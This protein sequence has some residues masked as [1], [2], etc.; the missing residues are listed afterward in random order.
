MAVLPLQ[1]YLNN[2]KG[3]PP[4]LILG[5][6]ATSNLGVIHSLATYHIP[7]IVL[8]SRQQS[9]FFSRYTLGIQSPN[10]LLSEREYIGF[11]LK[12]GQ[13]IPAKAVLIP[14]GD[15]ETL[16]LAKY[17][18]ELSPYFLSTSAPYDLLNTLINKQ[19]LFKLLEQYHIPHPQTFIIDPGSNLTQASKDVLYPCILKP[20]YPSRFRQDFPI[21]CFRVSS[22]DQF[23]TQVGKATDKGHA[24][25]AQE[26]IPGNAEAMH[27]F[28]AYFD[29]SGG[30]HGPFM[31]QRIREWPPRFGNGCY[32]RQVHEPVLEQMTSALLKPLKYHGIVDVEFRRDPRDGQFKF[33][34]INPRIWMQ[35][36]FPAS[37][38]CNHSYLAYVDALGLPL[39]QAE[40]QTD[41]SLRWVFPAEDIQSALASIRQGSL[42]FRE[43]L[44]AYRPSNIYAGFSWDDPFP[45][46]IATYR[47][48][49]W[50]GSLAMHGHYFRELREHE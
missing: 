7:T 41:T 15:T 43:W 8:D 16:L 50:V 47:T 45:W 21:K 36:N 10:P 28:N 37:L 11:L 17:S 4:A 46:V 35:C 44:A 48:L 26:I 1:R 32:L 42:S 12:L 9:T 29:K 39:P 38:G 2:F 22:P 33:I 20:V 27:G 31:Y 18:D 30:M 34:E 5:Q 3:T 6:Y 13:Q 25:I 19:S 49:A 14:T 40:A 23:L 24:M